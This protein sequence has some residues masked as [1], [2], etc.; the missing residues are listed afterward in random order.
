MFLCCLYCITGFTSSTAQ[1]TKTSARAWGISPQLSTN[2]WQLG[3]Q[4]SHKDAASIRISIGEI[5]HEKEIKQQALADFDPYKLKNKNFKLGKINH[6]YMLKIGMPLWNYDFF[7]FKINDQKIRFESYIGLQLLM[8]KPVYLHLRY[9]NTVDTMQYAT[10]QS[11]KYTAHNQV[12][13]NDRY[14][15]AGS[16][17]WARGLGEIKWNPGVFLNA[18][19]KLQTVDAKFFVIN[20]GFGAAIDVLLYDYAIMANMKESRLMMSGFVFADLRL[21][22]YKKK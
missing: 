17:R 18:Q 1:P 12:V 21:K 5:K 10:L 2:G 8:L 16:D 20:I 3:M 14:S 6:A 22:K 15:I 11:E 19:C 9:Y 13:F 7:S 4:Y